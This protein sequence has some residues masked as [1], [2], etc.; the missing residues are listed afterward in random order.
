MTALRQKMIEDMQLRGLTAKTQQAYMHAVKQLAE[1]YDKSPDRIGEKEL[2][3]YFLHLKNERQISNSTFRVALCGIKFF[4]TQTLGR[5]WTLLELVRPKPER[6]LPVILTRDEVGRILKCVR[7]P[8]YRVCLLTIYS[9]GLRL[10]EGCTLKVSDIDSQRMVIHIEQ[11]KGDQQLRLAARFQAEPGLGAVGDD[12]LHYVAL[13]VHLDGID[14]PEVAPVLVLRGGAFE[15]FRDSLDA[16]RQN[17]REA[18]QQ[19]RAQAAP[20]EVVDELAEIHGGSAGSAGEDLHGSL[21]TDREEATAPCGNAVE[22]EAVADG[23][24]LHGC[25]RHL[26]YRYQDGSGSSRSSP[27]SRSRTLA[28]PWAN[29]SE[30]TM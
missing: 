4:Y 25:P 15:G 8:I 20:A 26:A 19:R 22:F 6:R 24:S 29:S 2:R 14:A 1:H 10:T 21:L 30:P 27:L 16:A 17:V 11:G 9:C 13:L 23:P 12:L 7:F 28:T 5:E 3:Q 18:D